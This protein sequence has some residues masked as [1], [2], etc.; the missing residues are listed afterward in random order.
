MNVIPLSLCTVCV[1]D[2]FRSVLR[3]P[4]ISVTMYNFKLIAMLLLSPTYKMLKVLP[5]ADIAN[6]YKLFMKFLL[7][8]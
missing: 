4:T 7:I 2:L 3:L 8:S 6:I 1:R 5:T